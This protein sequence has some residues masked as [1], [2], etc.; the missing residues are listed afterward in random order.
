MPSP[1]LV[2]WHPPLNRFMGEISE[3]PLAGPVPLGE[4]LARFRDR[5]PRLEPFFRFG[6]DDTRPKGLMVMRGAQR[7]NLTDPV[8]PGDEVEILVAVQG[9]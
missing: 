8:E 4:L 1:S 7:L 5:E 3:V 2:K 9:G 6:A